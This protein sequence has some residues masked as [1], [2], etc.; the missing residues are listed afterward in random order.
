M[1]FRK[2]IYK[3][4]FVTPEKIG[5]KGENNIASQLRLI[6]LFGRE[7][8]ILQNIYVPNE[9]GTTTEIDLLYITRKGIF[10]IESKNYSGYIFADESKTNWTSTLYAGRNFLGTPHVE[11]H[12]FYN[13]IWQNDKHIR[14]LKRYLNANIQFFSIIVFSNRCEF[15]SFN[16]LTSNAHICQLDFLPKVIKKLWQ[17]YPYMLSDLE[18][19][20]LYRRLLILTRITSE[21]KE[22]HVSQLKNKFSS[23]TICPL[24]KGKLVRRTAKTGKNAGHDFLGC[25]NYP[26]CRYTKN[27]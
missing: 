14:A 8:K 4:L 27:I 19:D 23:T 6:D 26:S 18:V 15:K 22:V 2:S 12:K 20:E 25:S 17:S 7:G 5:R 13:P 10:V 16:V 3:S 9:D 1:G 24:C 21:E 11:A